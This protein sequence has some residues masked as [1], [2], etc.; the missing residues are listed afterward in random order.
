MKIQLKGLNNMKKILRISLLAISL[1]F[2]SCE[3]PADLN[4]NPNEITVSDVDANL[5]LNG[6]QLANVI[7][8]VSHLNRI[9]GMFSGQL[10]GYASLYSNIHGYSLSTVESNG[11]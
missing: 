11:E 10:V 5:F 9:S 3:I 2:I 4:D 1:V 7:V 8:Q 6:A